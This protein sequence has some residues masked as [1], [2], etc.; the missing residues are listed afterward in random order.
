MTCYRISW[1]MDC[2]VG[3]KHKTFQNILRIKLKVCQLYQEIRIG[4][5]NI[6]YRIL[7]Y[8]IVYKQKTALAAS[9]FLPSS[10]HSPESSLNMCKCCYYVNTY[11]CICCFFEYSSTSWEKCV[12]IMDPDHAQ[13]IILR[14][15]VFD[16]FQIAHAILS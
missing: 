7:G 14:V 8:F 9:K 15:F 16:V 6:E 13:R 3:N 1:S 2:D 11:V 5:S 10:P 4:I 12:P